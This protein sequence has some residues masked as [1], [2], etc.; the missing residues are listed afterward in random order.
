MLNV[1]DTNNEHFWA[2]YK[3][4]NYYYFNA[5]ILL[6]KTYYPSVHMS[7]KVASVCN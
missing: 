7:R 4:L 6:G 1:D 5:D 3:R 2:F